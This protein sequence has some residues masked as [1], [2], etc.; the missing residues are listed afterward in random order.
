MF[1]PSYS[2]ELTEHDPARPWIVVR[3]ERRSIFLDDGVNF[4]TWARKAWPEERFSVELD[5]WQLSTPKGTSE[6]SPS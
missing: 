3:Q 1:V 5:P 4:F 6:D 2:F